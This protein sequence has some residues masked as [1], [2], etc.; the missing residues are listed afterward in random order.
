MLTVAFLALIAVLQ[1]LRFAFGWQVTIEGTTVP[2]WASGIAA[3]SPAGC[4]DT[5]EGNIRLASACRRG[6]GHKPQP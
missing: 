4:H 2:V 3:L 5:L 6:F 1:L